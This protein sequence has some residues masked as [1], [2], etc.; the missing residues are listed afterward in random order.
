LVVKSSEFGVYSTFFI[1]NRAWNLGGA[2]CLIHTVDYNYF[3]DVSWTG[4]LAT[5]TGSHI[6]VSGGGA[7]TIFNENAFECLDDSC[8]GV[9]YDIAAGPSAFLEFSN[10]YLSHKTNTTTIDSILIDEDAKVTINSYANADPSTRLLQIGG[11][12]FMAKNSYFLTNAPLKL[13]NSGEFEWVG[14]V[15]ESG[16]K[17]TAL[18]FTNSGIINVLDRYALATGGSKSLIDFQ[19]ICSSHSTLTGSTGETLSTTSNV[20]VN[21]NATWALDE[22]FTLYT[23]NPSLVFQSEG[24]LSLYHAN[25]SHSAIFLPTSLVMVRKNDTMLS[26]PFAV[27]NTAC[28][29]GSLEIIFPSDP[30]PGDTYGIIGYNSLACDSRFADIS[31]RDFESTVYSYYGED[32][33][34]IRTTALKEN[35]GLG[36]GAVAGIVITFFIIALAATVIAYYYWY[37]NRSSPE[38]DEVTDQFVNSSD[39]NV[40]KTQFPFK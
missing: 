5:R 1:T 32:L 8:Q 10:I 39:R 22:N 18:N 35:S 19:L 12:F 14:G 37:N 33:L 26:A 36:G 40:R 28:L 6:Y 29:Q 21:V 4:N 15:L 13:A 34:S 11:Q 20:Y 24:V 38:D 16:G 25:F 2:V 9:R 31:I 3:R 27:Q 17:G 30:S 23:T 7:S